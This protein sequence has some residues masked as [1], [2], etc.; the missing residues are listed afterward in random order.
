MVPGMGHCR[1]GDGPN[2]FFIASLKALDAWV[3]DVDCRLRRSSL[4]DN[5]VVA[6]GR[7]SWE[8][9]LSDHSSDCSYLEGSYNWTVNRPGAVNMTDL[10]RLRRAL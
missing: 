6:V 7:G 8:W 10:G 3:T 2:E 9:H 5:G 4:P 1:G